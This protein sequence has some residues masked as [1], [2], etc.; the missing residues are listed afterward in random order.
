MLL[1]D[2]KEGNESRKEWLLEI[3]KKGGSKQ[4]KKSDNQVWQYYNHPE[5]TYSSK[6]MLSKIRYIHNNPVEAGLV[7][8]PEEYL[9]SSAQDYSG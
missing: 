1:N 2:I 4:K 3:F 6:F 5:E 7:S 8:R 9:F